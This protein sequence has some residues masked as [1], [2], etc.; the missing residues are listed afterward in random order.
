M[1]MSDH[2]ST[3]STGVTCRQHS[4]PSQK[5]LQLDVVYAVLSSV[6]MLG[7][8]RSKWP[9]TV[10][11]LSNNTTCLHT[12]PSQLFIC[13]PQYTSQYFVVV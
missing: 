4:T 8:I 10:L 1:M 12:C 13:P 2:C 5:K 7:C 9:I 6:V 3:N 11:S